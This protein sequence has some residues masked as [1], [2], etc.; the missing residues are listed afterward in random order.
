MALRQRRFAVVRA[1]ECTSRPHRKNISQSIA[2]S[3]DFSR[4]R[5]Y[6]DRIMLALK[7]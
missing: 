2:V 3:A 6:F 7:G 5:A 1:A 4:R